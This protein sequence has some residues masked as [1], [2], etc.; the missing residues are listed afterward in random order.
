MR[1]ADAYVAIACAAHRDASSLQ[2][3]VEVAELDIAYDMRATIY[4]RQHF[5]ALQRCDV[6]REATDARDG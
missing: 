3:D 5:H 6:H 2:D 4:R 1:G